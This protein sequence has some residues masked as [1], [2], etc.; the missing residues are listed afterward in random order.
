MNCRGGDAVVLLFQACQPHAL[1]GLKL[2]VALGVAVHL[3][4]MPYRRAGAALLFRIR[5]FLQKIFL[6]S[7]WKIKTK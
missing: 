4:C 1:F 5:Q 3:L 7:F 2:G 6:D